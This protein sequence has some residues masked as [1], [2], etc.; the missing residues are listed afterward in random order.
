MSEALVKI[1]TGKSTL[2]VS[3]EMREKVWDAV[4]SFD[5]RVPVSLAVGV[6]SVVAHELMVEYSEA[7]NE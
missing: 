1:E 7:E 2:D 4:H 5:G 3:Q 6:L